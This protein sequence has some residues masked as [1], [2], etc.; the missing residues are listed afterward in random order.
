M[1][2]VMVYE[3]TTRSFRDYRAFLVVLVVAVVV[4]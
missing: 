3:E 4:F 1:G 2:T